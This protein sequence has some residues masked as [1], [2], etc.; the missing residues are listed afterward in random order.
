MAREGLGS[1]GAVS[2]GLEAADLEATI[3]RDIV[4]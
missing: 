3:R 4:S 2:I 1:A